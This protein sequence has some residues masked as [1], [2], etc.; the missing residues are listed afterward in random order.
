MNVLTQMI[1]KFSE[2]FLIYILPI[3]LGLL[4]RVQRI[5]ALFMNDN[6]IKSKTDILDALKTRNDD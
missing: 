1:N 6:G 4:W 3:T 2:S 5:N